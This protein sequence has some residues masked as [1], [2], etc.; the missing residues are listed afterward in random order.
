MLLGFLE[1]WPSNATR[2]SQPQKAGFSYL[3]MT[4]DQINTD[5]LKTFYQGFASIGLISIF[6][7]FSANDFQAIS[8]GV[9]SW[10]VAL[11]AVLKII[12]DVKRER[13]R[14]KEKQPPEKEPD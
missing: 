11:A 14:E 9:A 4:Q 10:V 1:G 2:K 3:N 6:K 7:E 13:Q 12:H 5:I 8:A